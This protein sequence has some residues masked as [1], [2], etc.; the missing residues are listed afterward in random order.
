MIWTNV[1]DK[2]HKKAISKSEKNSYIFE[3]LNN[4]LRVELG[5][6][7]RDGVENNGTSK[8]VR[9]LVDVRP[10]PLVEEVVG[11]RLTR[12]VVTLEGR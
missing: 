2:T 8:V 3:L 4:V 7:F 6:K 10:Q 1:N 9:R 11:T 5:A 12:V